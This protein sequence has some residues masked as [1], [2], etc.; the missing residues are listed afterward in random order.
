[1]KDPELDDLLREWK[2]DSSVPPSFQRQI[3]HRIEAA[4]SASFKARFGS[5]WSAFAAMMMRPRLAA[6]AALLVACLGAGIG[7]SHAEHLLSANSVRARGGAELYWRS[8]NPLE[9]SRAPAGRNP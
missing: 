5:W 6:S 8:I 1:M 7:Y 2:T 4:E 9:T 3:W